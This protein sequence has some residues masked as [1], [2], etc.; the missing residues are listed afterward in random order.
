MA[1]GGRHR[2]LDG[3]DRH[4]AT[5]RIIHVANECTPTGAIVCDQVELLG[6]DPRPARLASLL[7]TARSLPRWS[8]WC[9][10]AL[11]IILGRSRRC[12]GDSLSARNLQWRQLAW[13]RSRHTMHRYPRSF[14]MAE[15]KTTWEREPLC[16]PNNSAY[17]WRANLYNTC[18]ECCTNAY[19]SAL[20]GRYYLPRIPLSYGR[21]DKRDVC[22]HVS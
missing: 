4:V 12:G 9:V 10:L 18:A 16:S 21:S 8:D 22:V 19:A 7:I 14:T 20:D 3:V 2:N 11:S 15:A 6:G 13:W 17:E 5:A 1:Y